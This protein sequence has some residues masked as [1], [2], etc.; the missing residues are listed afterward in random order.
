M[1]TLIPAGF[2]LYR[3][4]F[5][6]SALAPGYVNRSPNYMKNRPYYFLY[7][8]NNGSN[9]ANRAYGQV[10]VFKT[11]KSLRLINLGNPRAVI[12]LLSYTNDPKIIKSIMKSFRTSNSNN[13]V[14]SSKLKYDLDVANFVCKLGMDGYWAPKLKQ[15]YGNK[16]FH[17]E[18]VLC[19]P[20]T[21]IRVVKV[22]QP[23]RAPSVAP[24]RKTSL[25]INRSAFKKLNFGFGNNN[26]FNY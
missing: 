21:S 10:T 12:K 5:K 23:S 16:K 1:E 24:K 15:K 2:I 4:S 7:N 18:I 14:R 11:T 9:I 26:N 22:E 19:H 8:N 17:Q 13:V 25:N 6:E 20:K 3:G